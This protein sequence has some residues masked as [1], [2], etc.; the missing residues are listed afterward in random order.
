[1]A[2]RVALA[3]CA[4]L[5]QL[6]D[7]EPMLLDELR[8][9][10]VDAEPVVWDDPAVDWS[11]YALVVIRCTWDYSWRREQFVAWAESVPRLL[12]AADVVRWN[13]DKRYLTT[14]PGAVATEFVDSAGAWEP[15]DGEFVVKPTISSGSRHTARY[16]PG[17]AGQASAHVRELVGA[18]R[19]VMVQPYLDAVDEHGETALLFLGGEYSHAIRKGQ[20]LRPGR[21]PSTDLFLSEQIAART[22]DD[23]ELQ[24][25][26]RILDAL[27]WPRSELLYARVDLIPG[28]DGRPR[29]V[30]LE[31]TEPSLY[32]SFGEGAARRLAELVIDRI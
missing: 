8:A 19:T 3:T 17:D 16:G 27:P 9:R 23:A 21:D 30:E 26:D 12:N 24:L 14:L 28:A 11:D 4:E 25:A 5:P 20:M 22:P 2:S 15:P 7:D 10:S 1:V 6:A 32:F 13:T 29:L 18:G 31:L